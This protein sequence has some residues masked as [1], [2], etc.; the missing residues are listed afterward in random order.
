M[1]ESTRGAMLRCEYCWML[2]ESLPVEGAFCSDKC[3]K[4]YE[5]RQKQLPTRV[6]RDNRVRH[7][8]SA[9]PV[10]PAIPAT[11]QEIPDI[12]I[13]EKTIEET[14][15]DKDRAW[16]NAGIRYEKMTKRALST[17]AADVIGWG[18]K[19]GMERNAFDLIV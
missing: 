12:P 13:P 6:A 3:L 5:R 4:L 8:V 14:E 15:E 7:G 1:P 17:T 16:E 9:S 19:G 10:I 11:P 18:E 2:F